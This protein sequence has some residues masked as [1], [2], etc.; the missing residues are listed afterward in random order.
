MPK[1]KKMLACGTAEQGQHTQPGPRLHISATRGAAHLYR[2][3]MPSLQ[4]KDV[5]EAFYKKDLAK[6]LLLG[7]SASNDAEKVS[8]VP[9]MC[10]PD[11]PAEQMPWC[12]HA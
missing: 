11:L 6:R 3:Q 12:M 8:H 10:H 5:F 2:V 4:G 1:P 9:H 7:R